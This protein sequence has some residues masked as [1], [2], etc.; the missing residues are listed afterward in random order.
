M[1]HDLQF[2]ISEIALLHAT[3]FAV[4]D[5]EIALL[6]ATRFAVFDFEIALLHATRFAVLILK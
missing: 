2:L 4:F 5:F 1:Q 6:H 3:R